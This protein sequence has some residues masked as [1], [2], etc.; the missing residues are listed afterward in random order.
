MKCVFCQA[1]TVTYKERH[2]PANVFCGR[3]CQLGFHLIGLGTDDNI[4]GLQANDGTR[5][6]LTVEQARQMKTIE[7]L[8]EDVGSSEYIPLQIINGNTLLMIEGFIKIG[9]ITTKQLSD[10]AF[11]SLMMAANYLYFER[12]LYHLKP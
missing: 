8:L 4:V 2:T 6:Q 5:I 9:T 1:Q 10:D 7:N 11:L 3:L 12:L